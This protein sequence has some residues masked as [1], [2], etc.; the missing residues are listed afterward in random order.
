MLLKEIYL[1]PGYRLKT[2]AERV[3]IPD[4]LR[5]MEIWQNVCREKTAVKPKF[6][7]GFIT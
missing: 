7:A 1:S 4:M 3:P 6:W 2:S 5:P